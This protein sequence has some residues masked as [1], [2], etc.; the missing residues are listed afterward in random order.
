MSISLRL[1]W[2]D[3]E[4]EQLL[5]LRLCDLPLRIEGTVMEQGRTL[6]PGAG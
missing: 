4:D 2:Q 1:G 3:L 5:D 6:V